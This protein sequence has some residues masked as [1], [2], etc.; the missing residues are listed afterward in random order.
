[1]APEHFVQLNLGSKSFFDKVSTEGCECVADFK[2]AVKAKFS[3]ILAPY[4]NYELVLFQADRTTELS[5]TETIHQLNAKRM[6]LVVVVDQL[7]IHAVKGGTAK[8]RYNET[9]LSILPGKS[10]V[11]AGQDLSYCKGYVCDGKRET[12]AI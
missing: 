11:R 8:C 4:G 1:M 10:C 6:P 9:Q 3:Q 2:V 7:E 12:R 5:A